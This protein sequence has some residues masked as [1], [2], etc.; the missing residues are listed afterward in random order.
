V[1]ILELELNE[2]YLTLIDTQKDNIVYM[3]VINTKNISEAEGHIGV[4]RKCNL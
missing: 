3:E 2:G 1:G 4:H